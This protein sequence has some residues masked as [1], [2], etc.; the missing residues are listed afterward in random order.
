MFTK[1]SALALLAATAAAVPAAIDT[2]RG[3]NLWVIDPFTTTCTDGTCRYGLSVSGDGD[4]MIPPF[5]AD[6][7]GGS[8]DRPKYRKCG[9]LGTFVGGGKVVTQAFDT[10][11]GKNTT[12]SIRF[13]FEK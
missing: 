13:S 4:D 8:M 9:A 6:R 1:T 11:D 5:I 7:C 2:R 12:V 10:E 3:Y